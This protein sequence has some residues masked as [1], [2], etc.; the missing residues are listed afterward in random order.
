MGKDEARGKNS[1]KGEHCL[2]H[3]LQVTAAKLRLKPQAAT[4]QNSGRDM[5]IMVINSRANRELSTCP[6]DEATRSV[7]FPVMFYA[8]RHNRPRRVSLHLVQKEEEVSSLLGWSEQLRCPFP[9]P[10]L[11]SEADPGRVSIRQTPR[12]PLGG[13]CWPLD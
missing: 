2:L 7:F 8:R 9:P 10:L 6:R 3:C 4:R 1:R 13:G 11:Q 12:S 5:S